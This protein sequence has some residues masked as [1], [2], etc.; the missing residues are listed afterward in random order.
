ET[1][2][3]DDRLTRGEDDRG[4]LHRAVDGD[5]VLGRALV[6]PQVGD[7]AG[8]DRVPAARRPR[9]GGTGG[10][11]CPGGAR[12][13]RWDAAGEGPATWRALRHLPRRRPVGPARRCST[14]GRSPWPG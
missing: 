11:R 7:E 5:E 3:G 9:P 8:A 1:A 6:R 13:L 10:P 4:G 12:E 14:D 2:H